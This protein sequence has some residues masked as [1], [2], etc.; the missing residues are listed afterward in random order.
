MTT[1]VAVVLALVSNAHASLNLDNNAK[2][3]QGKV[4][5]VTC[6]AVVPCNELLCVL[7]AACCGR[8]RGLRVCTP[9]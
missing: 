7:L 1:C 5:E 2:G 3:V 6:S 4:G 8:G 9:C